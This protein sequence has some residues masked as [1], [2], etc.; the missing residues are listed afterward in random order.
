MLRSATERWLDLALVIDASSSMAIW[1]DTVHDLRAGFESAGMF[2]RVRTWWLDTDTRTGES[3]VLRGHERAGQP[4]AHSPWELLDPARRRVTLVISD[5]LGAAW[6]DRRVARLLERWARTNHV[7]IVQLFPQRLWR[8]CAPS[9]ASVQ[10]LARKPAME[11]SRFA[12]R[13]RQVA[14]PGPGFRHGYGEQPSDADGL[15]IPVLTSGPR[16]LERWAQIVCGTAAWADVPAMF[17]GR[18]TKTRPES[19][20]EMPARTRVT[21]FQAGASGE[22]YQLAGYLTFARL[23]L[24]TMRFVQK[25]MLPSSS[26]SHLAEVLSGGLL[27]RAPVQ[28]HA[29]AVGDPGDP[30]VLYEFHPGVRDLLRS[31]VQRSAGLSVLRLVTGR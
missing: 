27:V 11:N 18:V 14:D 8:R 31:S 9:V 28:V 25:T 15:P 20:A 16:W 30:H 29:P 6:R 17:T 1:R 23:T 24:P 13:Y 12:V 3:F 5:C 19:E 22:A 26:A 10:I 4:I 21:R 7:S 2:R